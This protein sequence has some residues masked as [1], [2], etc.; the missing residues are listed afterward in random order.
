MS[1]TIHCA[2]CGAPGDAANRFCASCGSPRPEIVSPAVAPPA[3]APIVPPPSYAGVP[4]PQPGVGG[5][6]QPSASFDAKGFLRSLYDFGFTSLIT[7]KVIRFVY[8][9]LVI[10][11][12]IGAVF[13]LIG[14]L[15]SNNG[16]LIVVGL[17]FVPIFYLVYLIL[18]RITME[19][20]VVFFK[21]GDDVHAIRN[22]ASPI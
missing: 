9:L 6:A 15:A 11:Y 2:N 1:S 3:A 4:G 17:I 14:C 12:S 19:L 20:I 8:A 22:E 10:V 16:P 7:P 13:V 5:G 21:I 18:L